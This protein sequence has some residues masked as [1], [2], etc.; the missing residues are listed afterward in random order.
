VEIIAYF[1]PETFLPLTSVIAGVAG[2]VLMF[3]RTS[4]RFVVDALR[5]LLKLSPSAGSGPI[6]TSTPAG[7]AG[8]M[9]KRARYLNRGAAG[10]SDRPAV[11]AGEDGGH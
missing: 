2:V 4:W 7:T 8:P 5:R 6:P 1:G 3:G 10:G 11:S 9:S